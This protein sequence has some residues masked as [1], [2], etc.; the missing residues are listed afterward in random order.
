M[1]SN[2]W[3]NTRYLQKEDLRLESLQSRR[4]FRKLALLY[5]IYKSKINTGEKNIFLGYEKY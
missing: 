1:F 5:K 2:N 4:W 3:C